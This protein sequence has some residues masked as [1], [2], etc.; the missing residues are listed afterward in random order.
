ML[1]FLFIKLNAFG[2]DWRSPSDE[3]RSEVYVFR[4]QA[5]VDQVDHSLAYLLLVDGRRII[6][7]LIHLIVLLVFDLLG[8]LLH[9]VSDGSF[10]PIASVLLV[11]ATRHGG[12]QYSVEFA[13]VSQSS[14]GVFA[15]KVDLLIKHAL[16]F[17]TFLLDVWQFEVRQVLVRLAKVLGH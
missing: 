17:L 6:L 4:N 1:L 2:N 10:G 12:L 13:F 7:R 14:Q 3:S 15:L 5:L 9:D 8:F 16:L 11:V